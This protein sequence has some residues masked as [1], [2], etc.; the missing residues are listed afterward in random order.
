[1]VELAI[2]T[3]VSVFGITVWSIR[4][5]GR[6]N[7]QEQRYDDLK[8]LINARFDASDNRLTRIEHSMNGFLHR[9]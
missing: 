5:E 4:L 9:D 1:M 7:A 2:F 6:V 8:E 3:I